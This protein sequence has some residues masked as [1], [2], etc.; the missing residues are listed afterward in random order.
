[1]SMENGTMVDQLAMMAGW[2]LN[3]SEK[4][5]LLVK[6]KLRGYAAS[7]QK[8]ITRENERYRF[9]IDMENKRYEKQLETMRGNLLDNPSQQAAGEYEAVVRRCKDAQQKARKS[10]SDAMKR[11]G[12]NFRSD[13]MLTR[14]GGAIVRSRDS[15]QLQELSRGQGTI[16]KE[17]HA[18]TAALEHVREKA[19]KLRD[20]K[21]Q[22]YTREFEN[23]KHHASTDHH[24]KLENIENEHSNELDVII[25]S[26]E[27]EFFRYFN[28]GTFTTAY[29]MIRTNMR[30][31][32]G[33]S[34]SDKIPGCMYL[35]IRTFTIANTD[36]SF[37]P[38]VI[39]MFR[40]ID[41]HG[42]LT[43]GGLIRVS[44]PFFRTLEEGYSIFMDVADAAAG[45]SNRVVWD[46]TM[47]VLMNFPVGQT[48]PLLLD[49]DSTTELT[50][51]KVIGDSSGRNMVTKPWISEEDIETELKKLSTENTNLTISYGKD[52]ASRM[53]REPIYVVSCRNFPRSISDDAMTS[54]AS[55]IS[56]GASRGFF[57]IIQASAGE[58]ALRRDNSAFVASLDV[59]RKCSL[60]VK[61]VPGGYVIGEDSFA[62]ENM[63]AVR[64]SKQ[65]IFS[66]LISGVAR[67]RRQIEK[68]EYLF[69]KDAGNIE[70][71]DMHDIN[72]W[73]RA[74]ASET[75]EVPIGISGASTVQKYA[76]GGVAQH[77][78]IS[79][80][81]GSGKSTLLKTMIVAAMM[82]YTPDNL[83]LYLIDFKEGV[84]FAAFSE[85]RLPW[86]KA[87]ALNTQRV[88]A[89]NILQE[90][91]K[92]FKDRAS[93]MR[94][95]GVNHINEAR[96]KFPRLLLVFDEVQALLSVDDDITKQCISILS[97]LVSEGRAMNI[98]VIMASQNFAICRGIDSLKA[99]MVLRIAMKGSPESA[100]IV[101]GE[102]FSVDQ[103]EQ[104]DS[105]SAA[106]NTASG[107]RGQTT[108]FQV[109]YME[110]YEMKTLL[111]QLSMTWGD[112]PATTRI[113]AIHVNQ[114]RNAKF[115]RLITDGEVVY[116]EEPGSYELM[117]GDEFIM[118]RKRQ[119]TI[120][121]EQGENL[122]VVGENEETAKSVFALSMLSV[123]YGELASRAKDNTNELIRLV[124]MSD[125]YMPDAEY[126]DKIASRF[127]RQIKRVPG[128]Q[129][130][131]MIQDTYQVLTDRKRG[132]ADA[133]E[134]L[135]LM[136]FGMDSLNVLK[137][138][139]LS[140]D[141]G[142]LS[143]NRKLLQ[144]L[145]QG[146]E[147]GINCIL[148]A[149]S[150]D[151][152]RSVVDS[153]YINRYF[154]KRIYFGDNEDAVSVLGIK[155][156][157][158]ELEEKTVAYRDMSK[159][160][161]NAFR[162]FE[163]P[164][165]QWLEGIAQAYRNFVHKM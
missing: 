12:I 78:L 147:L 70:R 27:T 87:I 154:N 67:Y 122:M 53:A 99:N 57:G 138:E 80:V 62:F 118:N 42:V 144:I 46:Y 100:K 145:Q 112:L 18:V 124:D 3:T 151:G 120:T 119:I 7:M 77:G 121:P 155:Y 161:P 93:V 16:D 58:L 148:W 117:L 75:L 113:M 34:C 108:F 59:I 5:Y 89:L 127:P 37:A 152:F 63:E 47:K 50:D 91:Q 1:M 4:S 39:N 66:H 43:A 15:G 10:V 20:A 116:S 160:V 131:Q 109:G 114:D 40:R 41:H 21:V 102:D 45:S 17:D 84:E 130:A 74:D 158:K 23:A 126:L 159:S 51:F 73:Y 35:G 8:A 9:V 82:K 11:S 38:E 65:D 95:Q 140:E 97:E 106:I 157:M 88:F 83:N 94:Q 164:D 128:K 103:L 142:E 72:T 165:A 85:Y 55:V 101:M 110:D 69:S 32:G 123:L 105:G 153:V 13:N 104:G 133:S 163:L 33:Y 2:Q 28:A 56:A 19:R 134:R 64:R 81:T 149:R 162:V 92:E 68:F 61:E 49:C 26:Y 150:Y 29:D 90:L 98:N 54:L 48:R 96:D 60:C 139:M 125:D 156:N 111:G 86:I 146:P 129:V 71:M 143:L 22:L 76:I 30:Q 115:N 135:F 24:L 136:I 141:E 107:A 44:L 31:A 6:E 52:I 137:Q 36:G 79:G 14:I 132:R 25:R